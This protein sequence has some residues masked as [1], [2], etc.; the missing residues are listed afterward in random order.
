MISTEKA[1]DMLPY[2]SDIYEELDIKGYIEENKITLDSNDDFK[3]KM[4]SVGLDMF[5]YVLKNTGKIKE[6]IFEVV[7]IIED[8]TLEEVKAQSI[9]KTMK[10]FKSLFEDK[11]IVDFFKQATV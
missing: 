10:T 3:T 9:A 11:D 8:K 4:L 1:F 7:A 2:I 5:S 6:E